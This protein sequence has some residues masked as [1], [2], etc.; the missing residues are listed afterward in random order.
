L[1]SNFGGSESDILAGRRF[2]IDVL[3]HNNGLPLINTFILPVV[4]DAPEDNSDLATGQGRLVQGLGNEWFLERIV[5]KLFLALGLGIP[6]EAPNAALVAAGFFVA[7]ANDEDSGGG[8]DF[9]IGSVTLPERNSNYSPLH[10]DVIREP[11]LWRRAWMLGGTGSTAQSQALS[12]FPNTTAQYGS[13][14]DG[15]HIDAKSVRRIGADERLWFAISTVAPNNSE[16]PFNGQVQGYLDL[17]VL[18]ALRKA[19]GKSTF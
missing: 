12:L 5:G 13:I 2:S 3:P 18:G 14:A 8:I 9:P 1:G 4:P 11:W 16:S 17:R 15:G 10:A 6:N 7:R 19:K